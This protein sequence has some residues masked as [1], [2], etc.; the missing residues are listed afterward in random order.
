[1]TPQP[2]VTPP[3]P[4]PSAVSRPLRVL[5][6]IARLNIGGPARHTVILNHGLREIGFE[7]LL[8]HGSP[9]AAEGSLEDL[10]RLRDVATVLVPELGRRIHPVDDL[11]AFARVLRIVWT[12]RPDVVHTHTAKAGTIGRLAALLYNVTRPKVERCATVH[13]F[14]GHVFSSYFGTVGSFAIRLIEQGLGAITDR[15]VAISDRQRDDLVGRFHIA[16]P[17]RVIVVPLGLDIA[18][19]LQRRPECR[20]VRA[21]LG[22]GDDDYVLGFV[23][24]L[25]PVKDVATLL[26][27]VALA[28]ARLTGLKMVIVGDGECR[29]ALEQLTGDLQLGDRVRFLGWRRDLH[30]LYAS[31]D[32]FV[33]SSLNEGTPVALI[34]AMAAGVPSIATAVGGVPDVLQDGEHGILVSPQD[35]AAF[36]DAICR[37]AGQ[38]L[39]SA[40]MAVRARANVARRYAAARLVQETAAL[41][42]TVVLEKRGPAR[43]PRVIESADGSRH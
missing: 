23:G 20:G 42:V 34:E 24:R 30:D 17:G 21:D 5:R 40:E 33:L 2:A 43:F 36:A 39:R 28:R 6:L 9:G 26:R 16:A 25:V 1:M 18:D 10:A 13:T 31:F 35:P 38:P 29:P 22:F 15:I 32:L 8:V 27:A 7:T 37:A 19:L 4:E 3:L 11:R 41:Y 14:H 12:W